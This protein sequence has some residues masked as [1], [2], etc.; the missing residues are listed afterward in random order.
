MIEVA[1]KIQISKK[2]PAWSA[3]EREE[4][5]DPHRILGNGKFMGTYYAK[6]GELVLESIPACLPTLENQL[7]GAVEKMFKA[8][9]KTVT[10]CGRDHT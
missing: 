3:E 5:G 8:K 10:V 6:Y 7:K 2:P 1:L 9:V 4:L